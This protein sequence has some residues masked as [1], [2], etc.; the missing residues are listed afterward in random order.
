M[1]IFV[2]ALVLAGLVGVPALAMAADES[3]HKLS[4]NIGMTSNY[5]FRGIS[6][7]GGD[8]AVQGALTTRTAAASTLARGVPT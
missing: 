3:P 5:I 8:P 2:H 4:A 6:Q 7:T 1:K